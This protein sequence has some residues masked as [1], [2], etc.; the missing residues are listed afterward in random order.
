MMTVEAVPYVVLLAFFF[1]TSLIASR[2]SVGQFEPLAFIGLRLT[3]AGLGSI[4]VYAMARRRRWPRD[5][6]LWRHAIL[7]GVFG[8]AI[9]MTAVM[10]AL[11]HQSG[12]VTALLITAS[13]AVT[14]LLAHFFLPD[15]SLTRLKAIGVIFAL[16]GAALLALQGESGLADNSQAS[17]IGYTLVLVAMVASSVMTIYARKFMQDLDAF[18]VA[19]VRVW[20]A[21]LA[22][23]PLSLL[24]F[25]TDLGRV[26]GW[27]YFALIYS[28]VFG[29]F[30]GFF[31]AFYNIKRFGATAAAMTSYVI[32][33]ITGSG[34]VLLL[35]ETV[36]P[37][38][39]VGMVIIVS[40]VA[41]INRGS[42]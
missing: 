13:P 16:G 31:L 42:V 32:P 38:M 37:V 1:G 20:S 25:D 8:T 4:A 15:E 21:A 14:V 7:L 35:G 11:Q 6:R 33:I 34:G 12:G 23:M 17:S 28:A 19:S 26:D 29:T 27:G 36:T 5:H 30:A 18:D 24:L 41:F 39:I 3:L 9:P 40:G 22:V 2:F 10:T